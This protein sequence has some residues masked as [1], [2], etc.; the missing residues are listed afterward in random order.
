MSNKPFLCIAHRGA[1]G[2]A[3]ENTLKA[4][5]LAIE[6]GCSWVELDVHYVGGELI[7]IHDDLLDRTTD[8]TGPVMEASFSDLR[9]LDAG[10]RETIPTLREV[11]TLID[12]RA[13]INVELKGPMTAEPVCKL[14]N[15]FVSKGWKTSEFLLSSFNHKELAQADE[16]FSRGALFFKACDY[17]QKTR[18][19]D[20]YSI[21]LSKKLVS[22]ETVEQAHKE[23]LKVFVYTVDDRAEMENLKQLGVDGVFTNYPDHFPQ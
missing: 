12:H 13:G 6:M 1:S 16:Q 10:E 9:K 20:A 5:A 21:N 3:P 15:E 17:F 14:L 7:V 4:F 2:H 8:G 18:S 22:R 23:G 19:L 11:I